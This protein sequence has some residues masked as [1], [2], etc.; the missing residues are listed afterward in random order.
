MT[1]V[2]VEHIEVSLI[3]GDEGADRIALNIAAGMENLLVLTPVQARLLAT[4]LITAV[5]RAEVKASLKSTPNMWRRA[6]TVAGNP[7]EVSV[8]QGDNLP[9]LARA[10]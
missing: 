10:R 8:F 3:A 4:E 9:R 6:G 5:N 2:A 7:A 1:Q